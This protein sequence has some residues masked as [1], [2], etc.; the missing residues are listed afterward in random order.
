LKNIFSVLFLNSLAY[1]AIAQHSHEHD[2]T[3]L[4]RDTARVVFCYAHDHSPQPLAELPL[5]AYRFNPTDEWDGF[6]NAPTTFLGNI[7]APTMPLIYMPQ[8]H[9]GADVGLHQYD[10]YL[11]EHRALRYY[12]TPVAYSEAF[13]TQAGTQEQGTLFTK[14][15]RSFGA[16]WSAAFRYDN[17]NQQGIYTWN[18]PKHT[19]VSLALRY[20]SKDEKYQIFVSGI[21][22]TGKFQHNGGLVSTAD[23]ASA[24]GAQRIALAVKTIAAVDTQHRQS[25]EITQF[26]KVTKG[27]E[28]S[29]RAY[30]RYERDVFK[31]NAPYNSH[32]TADSLFYAGYHPQLAAQINVSSFLQVKQLTNEL[33]LQSP[34]DTLRRLRW[35]AGLRHSALWVYREPT[36]T[37]YQ[38][39]FVTGSV[40]IVPLRAL[41]VSAEG[42]YSIAWRNAADYHLKAEAVLQLG[43]A[44]SFE[45]RLL[46]QRYAPTLQ[47]ERFNATYRNYDATNNRYFAS[48]R[49]WR[50]AFLPTYENTITANYTLP[51]SF[52]KLQVGVQ[53]T[54]IAN[55]IYYNNAQLAAQAATPLNIAQANL[56][57]NL[58]VGHWHLDN[59]LYYQTLNSQS[60]IHL[61]TYTTRHSIY[62]SG[63]L[64]KQKLLTRIGADAQLTDSYFAQSYNP[65]IGQFYWQ[66]NTKLTFY[67]LINAHIDFVIDKFDGFVMYENIYNAINFNAVNFAAPDV[68]MRDAA[69]RFGLL[70]RFGN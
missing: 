19:H 39:L 14:L 21:D 62:W 26:W 29:H 61:P 32:T 7:G 1:C 37:S 43:A 28:V 24:S 9:S 46:A 50:N 4:A 35:A 65:L 30:Y 63:Q 5:T 44:G 6:A 3:T 59:A 70:W 69:F 68:P 22:N 58:K 51:L 10:R 60:Y 27:F 47:Q 67:P 45:A 12:T 54:T 48:Y 34:T 23:L 55:L 16:Q 20:R 15:A 42:A 33:I 17:Y 38:N 66:N 57:A 53:N 2:S 25:I 8:L 52:L 49:T 13:Y 18:R 56:T 11:A 36:D 31:D 40:Q 41:T 64:F